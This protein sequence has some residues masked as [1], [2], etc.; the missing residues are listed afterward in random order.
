MEL[1]PEGLWIDPGKLS[2][3]VLLS[4]PGT[5]S[6]GMI[7]CGCNDCGFQYNPLP[8]EPRFNNPWIQAGHVEMSEVMDGYE[9]V[10]IAP[11]DGVVDELP[12]PVD[13]LPSPVDEL[14]APVDQLPAP[15]DQL[16]APVIDAQPL[17][18]N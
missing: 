17:R 8:P 5:T 16:P 7:E 9:A 15:V 18:L 12:A 3:D 6:E 1:T 14:P 11:S 10:D 4:L 2:P 13:Q